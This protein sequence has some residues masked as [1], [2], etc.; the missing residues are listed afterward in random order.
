MD[1]YLKA[2]REKVCSICVDSDENGKCKMTDDESCAVELYIDKIV[3]VVHSVQ[4]DKVS[5]YVD[6]L[7][8]KICVECRGSSERCNLRLD[9]NCSLDRYFPLIVDVIQNVDRKL[10][11]S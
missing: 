2:I 5:D 11:S 8:Q 4:S 3:D 7:H 9:V 10:Y 6:A 1:T